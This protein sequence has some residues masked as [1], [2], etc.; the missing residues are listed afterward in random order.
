MHDDLYPVPGGLCAL[1]ARGRERVASNHLAHAQGKA[2]GFDLGLCIEQQRA[3]SPDLSGVNCFP[4]G[5][6]NCR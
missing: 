2:A 1:A 5:S 4:I 3:R 6:S